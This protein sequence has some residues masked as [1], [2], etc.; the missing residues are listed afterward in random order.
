MTAI[1][2]RPQA[3]CGGNKK[4]KKLFFSKTTRNP[5]HFW[6]AIKTK[7]SDKNLKAEGRIHLLENNILHTSDEH[8]ADIFNSYFNRVTETLE[9]PTWSNQNTSLSSE[10]ISETNFENHPSIKEINSHRNSDE[11]FDFAKV[12]ESQVFKVI[13]S[14]NNSKS[15]S[16]TIPTRMLK[17]AA[18]ICVP[19]LT[20]CFNNCVEDGIFPDRLK[21]AD[22]IPVFKKG[23]STDKVNYRPISLLP[24]VSKIF[25]RLIVNQLNVH[26]EPQ[27]SKLLCG[28]RK[29]HSTQHAILNMIRN[30]QSAIA[31]N[32][33]VG[34]VLIDL[35]KAFEC[36]PH[37]LLLA[38]LPAYGL[39]ESAVKLMHSYLSDRKHRVRIG[40]N[41]GLISCLV[42][43][44]DL[45]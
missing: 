45:F 40:S 13:A 17:I 15:V 41:F 25:E 43:H 19:Y 4:A 18:N 5:K 35:S 10:D 20:S 14:L 24:V 22:I 23:S 38:K 11:V 42:Y 1:L 12:D 6:D 3:P 30:W 29:G 34:A 8:V 32:L 16:G 44:K 21:L 26:F 28:F 31:N 27:F 37:D 33:K 7:F 39:S 9:I 36:L 2:G